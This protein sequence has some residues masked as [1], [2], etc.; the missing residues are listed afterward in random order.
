M[1]IHGTVTVVLGFAAL[2]G[3]SAH[4][5]TGLPRGTESVQP[6]PAAFTTDID[7]RYWPMRPGARWVYES[8]DTDGTAQHVEVTV[9]DETYRV[10]AG[11]TARVLHDVVTQDGA[12]AED[13]R[14]YYAQDADGN[15]WHLGEQ[16]TEYPP[17]APPST[18]SSWEA[19]VDGAQPGIAVPADPRP[20]LTYRQEYRAGEA[21]D[22]A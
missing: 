13:T 5:A 17:G 2:A 8:V 15:I 16:T 14:D 18:E 21:E 19:G 10:A 9:L 4:A 6:D 3:C 20:G 1:R 22:R 7:N 11:V 12:V